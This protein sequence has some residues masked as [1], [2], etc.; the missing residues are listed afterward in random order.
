MPKKTPIDGF[1]VAEK[2]LGGFA[3]GAGLG[4][5]ISNAVGSQKC[6]PLVSV[7]IG[8]IVGAVA[9]GLL[10]VGSQH[11]QYDI[12][13]LGDLAAKPDPDF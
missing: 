9:G 11:R 6:D 2:S 10:D 1:S 13:P 12:S 7:A 4:L 3:A 5:V 8:G